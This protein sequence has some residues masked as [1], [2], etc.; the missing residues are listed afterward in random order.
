MDPQ[1]RCFAIPE[2]IG[3]LAIELM[4]FRDGR[5]SN[6]EAA[7]TLC[8]TGTSHDSHPRWKTALVHCQ[9]VWE[10][11]SLIQLD[12]RVDGERPTN[13]GQGVVWRNRV[14]I[15]TTTHDDCN[16]AV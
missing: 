2:H 12:P 3:V 13:S 11:G 16:R 6:P 1:D 8:K 14:A 10:F 5:R 15:E 4:R 9:S 7:G